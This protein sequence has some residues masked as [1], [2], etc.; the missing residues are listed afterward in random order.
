MILTLL[1]ER[2]TMC[3]TDS[4]SADPLLVDGREAARLLGVSRRTLWTLTSN[5]TVPH[6]RIG[7]LVKYSPIDL[8]AYVERHRSE[9]S[10]SGR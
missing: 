5:G 9:R 8:Q 7:R 10:D 2:S 6:V 1:C 3:A 4:S